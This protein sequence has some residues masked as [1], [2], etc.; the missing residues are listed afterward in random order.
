VNDGGDAIIIILCGVY[1]YVI[2]DRK[3]G[4]A[5]SMVGLDD[6]LLLLNIVYFTWDSI[7]RLCGAV[8]GLRVQRRLARFEAVMF[9]SMFKD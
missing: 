4:L 2:E 7:Y 8:L 5:G 3:A 1:A 6:G 9:G